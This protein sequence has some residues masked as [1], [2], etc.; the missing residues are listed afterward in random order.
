MS[1]VV[2]SSLKSSL[3]VKSMWSFYKQVSQLEAFKVCECWLNLN[4]QRSEHL[5]RQS[6]F[7]ARIKSPVAT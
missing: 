1:Q 2:K 7:T 3:Y 4:D 6:P 5:L